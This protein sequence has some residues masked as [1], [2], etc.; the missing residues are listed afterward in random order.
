MKRSLKKKRWHE[1]M[2]LVT[3]MPV[4]PNKK[5]F[6]MD[7]DEDGSIK[8]ILPN[9]LIEYANVEPD[10]INPTITPEQAKA[11]KTETIYKK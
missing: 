9:T 8:S 10:I 7:S 6:I 1:Y 2:A 3:Q 11:L 5:M 4:D